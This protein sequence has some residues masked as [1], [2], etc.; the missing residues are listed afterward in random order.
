MRTWFIAFVS[1]GGGDGCGGGGEF[2]FAVDA[3]GGDEFDDELCAGRLV[4]FGADG[5]L[6]LLDDLGGD[7]EAEAGAA[8]LGGEVWEEEAL[9]HLVGEAGAGVGDGE[10]D[11]AVVEQ[12]GGDAELAEQA[13][14][15]GFGGVVDEVAEGALEG[16]GVGE[17]EREI[18]GEA[19]D[20]ADVLQAAGEEGEGVFDDGVEI[21]GA[22][23]G[24]G[25]LGESGELVYEG[26]HGFDR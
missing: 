14:L 24:G 6:V 23:A 18:G 20:D 11:H 9:A 10:L 3:G 17:D 8:L 1:V 25:E 16:F 19:A 5:A 21:G 26:A 7:G 4:L 12:G 22:G 15:H 13:R 2:G